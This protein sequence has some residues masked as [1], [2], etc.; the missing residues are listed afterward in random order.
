MAE[1]SAAERLYQEERDRILATLIGFLHDFDLAEEMMQEAFV[2]ALDQWPARG[3]PDNPRAW[4]VTTARNKAIDHIRR[5]TRFREKLLQICQ[6]IE[7]EM[8]GAPVEEPVGMLADD[9]LRLIFTC[10][11]PALPVEAQIPLTLRT[12][13]GLTTEEIA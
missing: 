13:C 10:C 7:D 11:H 2:A 6:Q 8:K 5:N 4:I 3:V 12:L 9:R 1:L